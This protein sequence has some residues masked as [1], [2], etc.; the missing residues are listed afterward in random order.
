MPLKPNMRRELPQNM[1]SP[2]MNP[3]IAEALIAAE[4]VTLAPDQ[5]LA[6]RKCLLSVPDPESQVTEVEGFEN[7][8]PAPCYAGKS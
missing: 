8:Q 2:R 5:R 7:G 4:L 1:A 3:D 6:A